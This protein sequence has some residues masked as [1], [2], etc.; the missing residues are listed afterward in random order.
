VIDPDPVVGGT[1]V[2]VV[3]SVVV[4]ARCAELRAGV[5]GSIVATVTPRSG[6][7]S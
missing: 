5:T 4:A 1:V 7:G 6:G 3:G 2:G